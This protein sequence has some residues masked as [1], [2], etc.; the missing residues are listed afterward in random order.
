MKEFIRKTLNIIVLI[1]VICVFCIGM[2]A[3][4]DALIEYLGLPTSMAVILLCLVLSVISV[5]LD[6]EVISTTNDEDNEDL[7]KL[8]AELEE[9]KSREALARM[10]IIDQR[11]I[12]KAL[13]KKTE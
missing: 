8:R 11:E 10:I 5:Y 4:I 13:K 2:C 6:R 7:S 12:I 3:I 1:L 9:S